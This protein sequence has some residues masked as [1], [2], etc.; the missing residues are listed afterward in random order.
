MLEIGQKKLKSFLTLSIVVW[1]AA[2]VGWMLAP[3]IMQ[4]SYLRVEAGNVIYHYRTSILNLVYPMTDKFYNDNYITFYTIE[5]TTL[6]AGAHST[7]MF[8]ILLISM[9][10][11]MSSYLKTI[12]NS[13]ITLGN[14][15][16]H[17][18]SK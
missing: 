2:Y 13:F 7:F 4:N 6:I 18:M 1:T 15:E 10:V 3:F 9:C 17:F 12:A 14:V 5:F 16:N 11:T 8:D